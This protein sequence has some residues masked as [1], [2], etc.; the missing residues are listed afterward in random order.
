MNQITTTDL[1]DFGTRELEMLRD[2]LNAML[3]DGIP[4]DFEGKNIVP[5]L[6]LNS[7]NVFLTNDE[8]QVCMMNGDKLESWYNCP[9]CGYEGF[10]EDMEA[11]EA[12]YGAKDCCRDYVRGV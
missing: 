5:M 7:G 8:F 11:V 3:K 10:M 4:E 2:I 6:N 12:G 9:E 1:N